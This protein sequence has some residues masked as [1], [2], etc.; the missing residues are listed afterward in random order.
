MSAQ[1]LAL[2]TA[3]F[4][5]TANVAVRLGLEYSTAS[6]ATLVALVSHLI[7][8]WSAVFLT[9]GIPDV[10]FAAILAITV[11]GALQPVI[12][13][14]HYIGIDKV[15]AS[16]AV[17]LRNSYPILSVIV[18]ITFLHEEAK[19]ANLAGT[20]FVVLGIVLSTWRLEK[21]LKSYR[22]WHLLYPL[23]TALL[24]GIVHPIRRY[25]MILSDEPLY[26]AALVGLISLVCFAG[27]L[28]LPI[29]RERLVWHPKAVM[30]FLIAGIFE[31][32]G[33]LLLFTAFNAGPVVTVSPIAATAP[34]WTVLL[35]TVFLRDLERIT[36]HT[37]IG[38]LC[39]VAGVIAISLTG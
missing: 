17:T 29:S 5:A 27:Y 2:F 1:L 35:A 8:L 37:V 20:L 18:G 6:T 36:A 15:G 22:W 13:L 3:L 31:T 4:Y 23:G 7:F 32:L 39:V 34:I 38:T 9:G 24:T 21:Q 19:I 14:G 26:F 11:A 10:S 30:P 28:L 16:R 25:A 33:I 12:R